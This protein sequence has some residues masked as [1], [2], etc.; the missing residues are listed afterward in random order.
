MDWILRDANI[1]KEDVREMLEMSYPLVIQSKYFHTIHR[2]VRKNM[3]YSVVLEQ[4]PDLATVM[5]NVCFLSN[6]RECIQ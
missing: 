5:F 3:Y 1:W 4:C 6:F 2:Y